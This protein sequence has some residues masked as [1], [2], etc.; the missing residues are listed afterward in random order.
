MSTSERR[1]ERP[2]SGRHRSF[3]RSTLAYIFTVSSVGLAIILRAIADLSHRP[4]EWGLLE[5]SLLTLICGWLSVKL[6]S[7][8]ATISISETFV[9]SGTLL[10]GPS[11][12]A[13]LVV[14]DALVLCL[15]EGW[16]A[17]QL[18]WQQ[19]IFNSAAPAISIWIAAMAAGIKTAGSLKASSAGLDFGF[20]TVLAIFTALYFVLNSSF[21]AVAIA[22]ERRTDPIKIWA[23]NFKELALNFGAGASIAAFVVDTK[24]VDLPFIGIIVPLLVV[25]YFTYQWSNERVA[26]EQTKNEQL[27]RVF[28]CTVEALALAIDAK[29]QVTHGHIRRVQ[30]HTLALARYL[31]ITDDK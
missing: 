9:L 31:E 21:V 16:K 30:R 26:S 20:V 29:D 18:R 11:A 12:G 15:K 6:P 25:V 28:L 19:V 3:N 14:F 24:N 22:L 10:Y 1:V 2:P 13:I 8:L 23:T 7:G 27:N 5:L 17:R 4:I